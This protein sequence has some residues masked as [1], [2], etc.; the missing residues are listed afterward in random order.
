MP[1]WELTQ[2]INSVIW[3]Y[4]FCWH[5]FSVVVLQHVILPACTCHTQT[6][7]TLSQMKPDLSA[8]CFLRVTLLQIP[9]QMSS[10]VGGISLNATIQ[11]HEDGCRRAH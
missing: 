4:T 8:E 5:E 9:I 3:S 2:C 11:T 1:G 6:S 10:I 7:L